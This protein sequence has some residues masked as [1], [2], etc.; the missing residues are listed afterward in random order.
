MG[1]ESDYG[2]TQ[3]EGGTNETNNRGQVGFASTLAEYVNYVNLV[4]SNL[5]ITPAGDWQNGDTVTVL[6]SKWTSRVP[7]RM[8]PTPGAPTVTS[9]TF[10]VAVCSLGPAA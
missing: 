9:E 8:S 3:K 7:M 5:S 6:P 2:N 4:A 1:F 10:S